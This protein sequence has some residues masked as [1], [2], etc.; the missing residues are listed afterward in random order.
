M[1]GSIL[2]CVNVQ[3]VGEGPDGLLVGMTDGSIRLVAPN[4][5]PVP[6]DWSLENRTAMP[7]SED[8]GSSGSRV[9]ALVQPRLPVKC[10][11]A[12]DQVVVCAVLDWDGRSV[13]FR[14]MRIDT[15]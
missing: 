13:D 6:L 7:L 4:A 3:G 8:E 2:K 11:A 12:M 10:I 1:E 9:S 14:A 15:P 5:K